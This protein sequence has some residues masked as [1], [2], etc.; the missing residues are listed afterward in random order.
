MMKRHPMEFL[1]LPVGSPGGP[2][3]P[4]AHG[5]C[6]YCGGEVPVDRGA[7]RPHNWGMRLCPGSWQRP[8]LTESDNV[9]ETFRV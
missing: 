3:R 9:N 4:A 6:V 8:R 5:N 1:E 2:E 7:V